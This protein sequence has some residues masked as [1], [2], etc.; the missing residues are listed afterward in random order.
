[1]K[2]HPD[3]RCIGAAN[4]WGSGATADYIGRNKMDGAFMSRFPVKLAWD[5]DEAFE[6]Q[7][8]GNADFTMRVQMA[9]KK[10]RDAGLK[11]IIDPRHSMAGSAL[12][13]AGFTSD[14]AAKL[15]YL[16]GLKEENMR[17]VEGRVF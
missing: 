8:S 5:Y 16:A 13:E 12:I 11:V 10:A 1:V 6:R 17:Q 4:T 3:F 7:I 15:T 9:R 2:R 14:E